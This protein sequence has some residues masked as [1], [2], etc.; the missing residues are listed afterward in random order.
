MPVTGAYVL[1]R[2]QGRLSQRSHTGR[3]TA[4][5]KDRREGKR[6]VQLTTSQ[7]CP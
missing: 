4:R 6:S 5:W 7:V 1:Q 3:A 2:C